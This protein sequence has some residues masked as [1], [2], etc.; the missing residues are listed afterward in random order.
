M[1][2]SKRNDIVA[3][4]DSMRGVDPE[5]KEGL[6]HFF[7]HQTYAREMSLKRDDVVVGKIHRYPCI[8]I[9]SKGRVLVGGEFE[10][11][12]YDAPYTWVSPAGTKRA[13]VCLEDCVWT[14]M[15]SNPTDT[16]DLEEIE[17][18]LIADSFSA[19]EEVCG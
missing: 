16:R 18:Y 15:W 2:L 1:D 9:L 17:K 19:L 8:N 10:A 4:E 6:R 14:G 13:I 5:F 12:S 7:G 11:E 3:L